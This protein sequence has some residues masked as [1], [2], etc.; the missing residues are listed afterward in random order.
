M[1]CYLL[2]ITLQNASAWKEFMTNF[3]FINISDVELDLLG[4]ELHHCVPSTHGHDV[5][6]PEEDDLK[7]ID[8]N[9]KDKYVTK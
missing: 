9:T 1:N 8:P 4:E 5:S 7:K 2:E 3:D 6:V